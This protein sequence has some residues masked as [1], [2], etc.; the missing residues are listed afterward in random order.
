METEEELNAKIMELTMKIQDKHPE[1]LEFLNELPV[2]IPNE[3]N[4]QINRRILMDYIESL[5]KLL[6]DF[7][8]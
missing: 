7:G 5:Q 4:P 1:L 2:T 8:D 6:K 3:N